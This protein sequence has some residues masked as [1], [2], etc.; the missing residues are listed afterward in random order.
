MR[1]AIIAVVGGGED[2]APPG[3]E[4][5][6]MATHVGRLIS[7][8]GGIVLC[9]GGSGVMEAAV[10][11]AFAISGLTIGIM[12]ESSGRVKP[13]LKLMIGTG[14][15]DARNFVYAA[16]ADAV[17]ALKGGRDTL[18]DRSCDEVEKAL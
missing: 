11:A 10:D 16:A 15:G 8:R 17:I 9:G 12:K 7:N 3:S 4:P 14:L 1:R 6:L 5:Y 2:T 18:R 13:H